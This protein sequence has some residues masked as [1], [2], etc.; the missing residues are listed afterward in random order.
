MYLVNGN[1]VESTEGKGVVVEVNGIA[2]S[3]V[4]L[5]PLGFLKGF[6]KAKVS[7]KDADNLLTTLKTLTEVTIKLAGDKIDLNLTLKNLSDEKNI[8]EKY[9]T[10]AKDTV[11]SLTEDLK[12]STDKLNKALKELDYYKVPTAEA[13]DEV[14]V[15]E[16]VSGP[17]YKSLYE[18]LVKVNANN[19]DKHNLTLKLLKDAEAELK[20]LKEKQPIIH[21]ECGCKE[22]ATEEPVSEG[23]VYETSDVTKGADAVVT[24]SDKI[25]NFIDSLTNNEKKELKSDILKGYSNDKRITTT[26]KN[27]IKKFPLLDTQVYFMFKTALNRRRG[28]ATKPWYNR[29]DEFSK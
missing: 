1:V 20:D 9:L 7:K 4:V 13:S 12:D 29:Y 27:W 24:T 5:K 14:G 23:S 22:E 16:E 18:D 3:N 10:E 15:V 2:L 28:T 8:L 26:L 19:V 21:E 6:G 17:D 11:T 25:Q